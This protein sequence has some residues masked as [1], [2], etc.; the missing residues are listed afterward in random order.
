M[1][2]KIGVLVIGD[3]AV[4]RKGLISLLSASR[5]I[6]IVGEATSG[7]EALFMVHVTRPHVILMDQRILHREGPGAIWRLWRENTATAILVF[8]SNEGLSKATAD[9]DAGKLGFVD[10]SAPLED[11]VRT[12]RLVT[13]DNRWPMA[14]A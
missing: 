8:G 10:T 5:S 4:E 11:W 14:P 13:G 3:H 12:I 7:D 6:S 2:D 1:T 9:L